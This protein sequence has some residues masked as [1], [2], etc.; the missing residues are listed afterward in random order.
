MPNTLANTGSPGGSAGSF[1]ARNASTPTFSRLI[2]FSMPAGVSVT[3][4]GGLPRRGS[5]VSDLA[6][7]PPSS[8]RSRNGSSSLP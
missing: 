3:R 8:S 2:A 6:T 4:G 1:S 5:T 7:M